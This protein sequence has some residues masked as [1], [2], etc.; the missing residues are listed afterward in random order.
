MYHVLGSIFT[1]IPIFVATVA[2]THLAFLHGQAVH[3][4][5]LGHDVT[6]VS[7]AS[8]KLKD[9]CKDSFEI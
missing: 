4:R 5:K 3:L 7:S 2:E 1:T 8:E 9:F 6:L